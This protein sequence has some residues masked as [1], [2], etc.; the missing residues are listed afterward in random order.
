MCRSCDSGK[1]TIGLS[2]FDKDDTDKKQGATYINKVFNI[3]THSMGNIIEGNLVNVN[4][5]E[6]REWLMV[7]WM[8]QDCQNQLKTT[9][10][11]QNQLS[12]KLDD[13]EAILSRSHNAD[14]LKLCGLSIKNIIEN[15]IGSAAG[16][17][18]APTI[19]TALLML[20]KIT[21]VS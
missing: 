16:G 19:G 4:E 17:A 7:L 8:L 14:E 12:N 20:G 10:E 6:N 3:E 2:G 13:L 18:V 9:A 11:G 15:T 21:G 5:K 1:A